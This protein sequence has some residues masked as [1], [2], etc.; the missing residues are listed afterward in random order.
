MFGPIPP[1]PR[2]LGFEDGDRVGE[3]A[4]EPWRDAAREDER[5][6]VNE[7][8]FWTGVDASLARSIFSV[9]SRSRAAASTG[10]YMFISFNIIE[11]H[12]T[13]LAVP[14]GFGLAEVALAGVASPDFGLPTGVLASPGALDLGNK[15]SL[16]RVGGP[17]VPK[18]CKYH[19]PA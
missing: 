5:E 3:P 10:L 16:R 9:I 14:N 2:A 12:G 15:S 1:S 18:G 13:H 19:I 11:E 17:L 8:V 7:V 4:R 6:N